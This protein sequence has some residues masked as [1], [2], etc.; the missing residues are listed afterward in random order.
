MLIDRLFAPHTVDEFI[1]DSWGKRFEHV[2][3]WPGKFADLLPWDALN[4]ILAEHSF[5]A[6]RLRLVTDGKPVART[7]YVQEQP[8]P[9]VVPSALTRHL[10]EGATLN[11]NRIDQM[12]A[13]IGELAEAISRAFREPVTV[14]MYAGWRSTKG[15]DLHWD[16]HDV[17]VLQ[18]AGRKHWRVYGDNRPYPISHALDG[19]Y[20]PPEEVVWDGIL[21]EGE[22]LYIPRG[23]W[24]VAVPMEEPSLH[25]TFGVDV[26]NGRHL[27]LWMVD[28]LCAASA[29][30]RKDLPRFATAAARAEHVELLRQD[31]L[32]Q[33]TPD[34]VDRFYAHLESRARP[35][36]TAGLPW[37][38]MAEGLPPTD[39][40]LVQ[41]P[42]ARDATLTETPDGRVQL[43][44]AGKR[45]RLA[46]SARPIVEPLLQGQPVSIA[47][48][49]AEAAGQ[50]DRD[51]VRSLLGKLVGQGLVV[52]A[53]PAPAAPR[54][55]A[56]LLVS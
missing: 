18:V 26:H 4:R 2:P 39:D 34:L 30:T 37:S 13:P 8:F 32:A 29:V 23:W 44:A 7:A 41:L 38:A 54:A 43:V 24:H 10:R 48:V 3:G 25:L 28:Q 9:R 19:S 27:L 11:I 1:R 40:F 15:F 20:P 56:P 6:Q 14:N 47:R 21:G 51:T 17:F 46:P 22:L 35:Q 12:Y 36:Q 31:L 50:V 55:E 52:V 5:D 16:E 53:G 33:L 42:A 49:V 45:L